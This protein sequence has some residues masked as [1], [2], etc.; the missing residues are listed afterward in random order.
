MAGSILEGVAKVSFESYSIDSVERM[1]SRLLSQFA[2]SSVL[3][4]TLQAIGIEL[5]DFHDAAIDVYNKR[6]LS[7]ASG[8]QLDIIGD[9]VGQGREKYNAEEKAWFGTDS[10]SERITGTDDAGAWCQNATSLGTSLAD[11][12]TYLNLIIAKIFKN[13]VQA[14]SLPE[15]QIFALLYTGWTVGFLVADSLD[16]LL[17]VDQNMPIYLVEDLL[18]VVNGQKDTTLKYTLPIAITAKI[19]GTVFVSV[20]DGVSTAFTPDSYDGYPDKGTASVF[21]DYF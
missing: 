4:Q 12:S 6:Q 15:C 17:V 3:N 14:A 2:N 11:D 13:H 21:T 20:E 16:I 1:K 7:L 9:I 8:E 10:I 18:K 19:V 5:Q